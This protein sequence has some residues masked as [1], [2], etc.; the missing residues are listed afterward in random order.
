VIVGRGAAFLL[1]AATTFRVR[2]VAPRGQRIATLSKRLGI[3]RAQATEKVL[4]LD[5]ERTG[6]VREYFQHD[7]RNPH[8]YDLLLNTARFSVAECGELIVEALHR[9]QTTAGGSED[10]AQSLPMSGVASGSVGSPKSMNFM[11]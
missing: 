6:F 8:C 2:L 9:W 10:A 7:P 1:P 3:D 5:R 11:P 4:T